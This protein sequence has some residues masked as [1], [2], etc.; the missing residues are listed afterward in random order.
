MVILAANCIEGI[1]LGLRNNFSQ[2]KQLVTGPLIERLKEKKQ[3]VVEA[4]RGALDAVFKSIM[5]ISENIVEDLNSA[6]GHK[7]PQV[8]TE[9]ILWFNRCL[10]AVRKPPG[11]NET[12]LIAQVLVKV[13][14]LTKI[15]EC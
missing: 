12:K 9:G 4:L 5:Q 2:Y 10:K 13:Q 6:A 1:A 15:V 7:N 8:K 3:N 11:K 14:V